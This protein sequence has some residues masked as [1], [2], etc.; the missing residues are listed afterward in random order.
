[1]KWFYILLVMCLGILFLSNPDMNDFR[2]YVE[3][4]SRRMI[5]E[6]VNAPGLGDALSQAG[7]QLAEAFV[8]NMTKRNNYYIF[9]TYE[10]DLTPRNRSDE[11]YKFLGIGGSFI[12]LTNFDARR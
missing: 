5:Q 9:S 3:E 6:G 4:E 12:N 1:M 8:D 2:E 7:S 10:I 11:P